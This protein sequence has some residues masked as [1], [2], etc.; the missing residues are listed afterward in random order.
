[1]LDSYKSKVKVNIKK[2]HGQLNL[3][4]KMMDDGR[5][6]VDIAQQVHAAIGMLKKVNNW[7]MESHIH[8]CASLKLTSNDEMEREAFAQELI[9][10]FNLTSK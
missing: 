6:C 4:E 5:Y 8:T 2:V 1:M 3:I 10:V 9:K 7:V